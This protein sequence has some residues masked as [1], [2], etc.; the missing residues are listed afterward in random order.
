MSAAEPPPGHRGG[1]SLAFRA[2]YRVL[3]W[4]DPLL[5]AWWRRFGLG[6]VVLVTTT[7]R[8]TARPR[9]VLL[10]L[11]TTEGRWYL[12]HPDGSAAWTRNLD[13]AVGPAP[14]VLAGPAGGAV[15]GPAAARAARNVSGPSWPPGS[16]RSPAIWSTAPPA[17]TSSPSAATTG[18][19]GTRRPPDG[20]PPH[21]RR[22][23]SPPTSTCWG[24]RRTR[25]AIAI[26]TAT[27]C[28][29]WVTER[30]AAR[31]W[32]LKLIVSSHRHWDHIGDNAAVMAAT[33]AA[34]AAHAL[35]APGIR[36]PR[37]AGRPV[38]DPARVCRPW[39]SPR[40]TGSRLRRPAARGPPHA[41]SHAWLGLPA[42]PRRGAAAERRHALRRW[43]GT[44]RPGGRLAGGDG[45]LDRSPDGAARHDP[46][47]AGSRSD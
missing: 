19:S 6:N 44:G 8:R 35:D 29:A 9:E 40:A 23:R 32:T 1:W 10:G 11:L 45:R 41:R 14:R 36:D 26:D 7:G 42:G 5:R 38:P 4:M 37:S 27:P 25:E 18:S 47:P 16:I 46:G 43:V 13:A 3:G 2:L 30:L 22:A 34:L 24:T 15:H 33:D 28:V 21:R 39:S 20:V 31:G 12:G 17:V